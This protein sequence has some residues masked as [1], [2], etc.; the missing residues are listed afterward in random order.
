MGRPDLI[1]IDTH[2]WIWLNAEPEKLS[3]SARQRLE[4]EDQVAI[5]PVSIY[6]TMVAVEKGR[7]STELES[8]TLVRRWLAANDILRVPVTDEIGIRARAFP[9]VH[10]DTFD[11]LIAATAFQIGIP[12][13]TADSNMLSLPWIETINPR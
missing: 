1:L 10:A 7:L 9:F 2:V 11:R 13:M 12:L 5:S 4:T 3:D 8:E 6:E